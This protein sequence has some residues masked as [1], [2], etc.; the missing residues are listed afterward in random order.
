MKLTNLI[1]N[2]SKRRLSMASSVWNWLNGLLIGSVAA[3]AAFVIA[4][5]WALGENGL[6]VTYEVKKKK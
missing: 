5:F 3:T 1:D 2:V 6:D 4:A